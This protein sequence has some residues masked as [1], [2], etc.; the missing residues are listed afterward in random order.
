MS[1]DRTKNQQ[2]ECAPSK[3]S[4]QPGHLPNLIRVFPVHSVGLVC[5]AYSVIDL[6][7]ISIASLGPKAS[8]K[9]ESHV[10]FTESQKVS[11]PNFFAILNTEKLAKTIN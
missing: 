4:N 2:N 3:D 7:L 11:Q 9:V 5:G 8:T 10:N 1:H 6:G